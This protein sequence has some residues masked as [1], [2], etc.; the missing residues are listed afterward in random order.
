MNTVT[1]N[2][3]LKI[4]TFAF[5]IFICAMQANDNNIFA[6][7]DEANNYPGYTFQ[8]E[9]IGQMYFEDE[10][11]KENVG[12]QIAIYGD[13]EIGAIL[14][15]KGLP[16][17]QINSIEDIGMH[18]I[19]G[20]YEDS[21]LL[22]EG[23][24][25]IRLQH[26]HGRLT[27]LDEDNNY[28]GHFS[29]IKRKSPTLGKVPPKGATIL[30][31][32]TNL[33]H[34]INESQ[35]TG[36]KLL[37]QG[38]RTSNEFG[39]MYLHLEARLGFMPEHRGEQRANSGI[40]IQNR[41]EVQIL[42]SFTKPSFNFGNAA[43]YNTVAPRV[44]ASYP[45]LTWQTYDIYFQAPRF[46][47]DGTKMENARVTVYLNGILVHKDIELESGTGAGASREEVPKA[48]LYLQDHGGD[49]I[50]FRNVWL[51]ED[52]LELPSVINLSSR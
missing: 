32:G 26:A 3:L 37:K 2:S 8:G 30:F 19:K 7:P 25:P 15:E 45:P 42:D 14:Y 48:E 10:T 49:P 39:D 11:I 28:L 29:K 16:N 43:L 31:D 46:N 12:L 34:F 41:Y 40:Y 44:N 13:K 22:L 18:K 27:A 17:E 20:K 51:I 4:S 38:A 50:H 35:M 9:Y 21:A 1:V 47:D 24:F 33:D 52:D 6:D 36:S 23:E 5:F